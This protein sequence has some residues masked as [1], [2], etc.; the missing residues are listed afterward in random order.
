MPLLAVCTAYFMVILDATVVTVALPAIDASVG[1]L[2]WIVDGYALAFGGLL[3]SGGALADRL[4]AGRVFRAGLAG[5][6]LASAACGLA[7]TPPLLIAARIAQG[8]AAALMVPASLAVLAALYSSPKARARALGVWGGVAGVAAASGPPLGGAL[9]VAGS[10]RLAFLVN[11]PVGLAALALAARYLP[12]PTLAAPAGSARSAPAGPD[13]SASAARGRLA[14]ADLPGQLAGILAL[15]SLTFALISAGRA[16]APAVA[17][18]AV[19]AA[20][21][22][23]FIAF[24]RRSPGPL[25]PP[26]LFA[27][28]AFSGATGVGLLLNLGFYGQLFV[29]SLYFQDVRHEDALHTGLAL[30]PEAALAMPASTLAGRAVARVGARLPM[31]AGLAIG[32]AGFAGLAATVDHVPYAALLPSLMA[33]GF[34]TGFTM[35]AATAAIVDAAPA[36]RAGLAAGVLN[37]SR[38]TGGAIGVALLGALVAGGLPF[39][40]GLRVGLAISAAAFAAGLALVAATAPRTLSTR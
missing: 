30:L 11:V 35:P 34:G 13:R 18:F 22:A 9:V 29:V 15:G 32:A 27:R 21:A 31:A 5:F 39:V 1:E 19:A 4:G 20:A 2:Q 28:R 3:L 14:P 7:P 40:S 24:E 12:R 23:A 38:Q 36:D 25:L 8:V 17:G 16:A 33:I 10:W 26:A 37:A 6:T